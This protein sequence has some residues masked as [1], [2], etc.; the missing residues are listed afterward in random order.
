[1]APRTERPDFRSRGVVAAMAALVSGTS[2][3][4]AAE[5]SYAQSLAMTVPRARHNR[6]ALKA[7]L[8]RQHPA[9]TTAGLHFMRAV[10][11]PAEEACTAAGYDRI[12]RLGQQLTQVAQGLRVGYGVHGQW[13]IFAPRLQQAKT[14]FLHGWLCRYIARGRPMVTICELGFMAGHSAML[15]LETARTAKVVSFD[16]RIRDSNPATTHNPGPYDTHP[17]QHKAVLE[18]LRGSPGAPTRGAR[19]FPRQ[20]HDNAWSLPQSALME[21]AYG[22]RFQLVE[23]LSNETVP[24]WASGDRVRCDALFVDGAKHLEPRLEDLRNFR[25]ITPVVRTYIDACG[26]I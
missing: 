16:V 24:R 15:F 1:M 11:Q 4:V 18:Q 17:H 19:S 2:V 5:H 21:R 8:R 3:L 14:R 9:N 12:E 6:L 13:G 10:Q 7:L 20:M 23:G 25:S 26:L 22:D